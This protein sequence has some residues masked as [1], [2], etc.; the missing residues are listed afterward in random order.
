MDKKSRKFGLT[1]K[2][3]FAMFSGMVIGLCFYQLPRVEILDYY[4]IDGVL[5]LGGKVFISILKMLVV[6]I[7]FIS[8]VNGT[9]NL[10]MSKQFGRLALKTITLYILTTAVAITLAITLASLLGIGF[11]H[12]V[13]TTTQFVAEQA[14]SI[15]Q[16]LLNLVPSNPFAALA[17][18][19]MLQVIIFSIL[20]GMAISTTGEA[21]QPV[22][23]LFLSFDK[24]I[25]TLMHIV[26]KVAPYGVFC[27]VSVIFARTGFNL[28]ANLLGYFLTVLAVLL[29]HLLVVYPILLKTLSGLSP[30]QFFKKLAPAMMFAFSTSSS[31]ASIPVVLDIVTERLGVKNRIAAFI[32]PLG[33]T[34]NMDGTAIMQGVATVFIANSYHIDIGLSGYLM[35]I[36]TAT[37]A[38]IGTAGIPSVGLITLTMVLQQVGLPIDAI[39]L[40]LGVDRL[41]DMVRTAVNISGDSNIACIVGKSENAMDI[42]IFENDDIRPIELSPSHPENK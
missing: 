13:K 18:G 15:K 35:V 10:G 11:G 25:M 29:I 3:M 9:C 6:P 4:L 5:D 37:L 12:D 41:L 19:E 1:A 40:I 16:V 22:R 2:I 39:G 27:L 38:S 34:I 7:V 32:I 30:V 26:L 24:I 17:S 20:F 42:S 8:L 28:I 21:S 36:L 23:D 33:A 14:P 31:S